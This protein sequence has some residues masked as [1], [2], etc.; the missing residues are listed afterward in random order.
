M[1]FDMTGVDSVWNA[2]PSEYQCKVQ[3]QWTVLFPNLATVAHPARRRRL[4]VCQP[5]NLDTNLVVNLTRQ[6]L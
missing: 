4:S 3:W 5:P 2:R 6:Y 1:P